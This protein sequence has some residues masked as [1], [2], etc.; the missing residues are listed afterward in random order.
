MTALAHHSNT[1]SQWLVWSLLVTNGFLIALMLALSKTATTQG[2]PATAYAFWQTLI[3]GALLLVR[4][5]SFRTMI[6]RPLVIYFAISGLA[7]IAIPNVLAFY[8]VTKLGT[9]F[10][11]ILYALPPVFTFLIALS[12]GM[13]KR[14]WVKLFGLIV[15]VTACGWIIIQRHSDQAQSSL[16]WYILGLLIPVALS[17]GN[18]YRS[19]AWPKKCAPITLASGTLLACAIM[20]GL[21]SMS[22]NTPLISYDFAPELIEVV[23]LQGVLTAITYLCAFEI[24]KRASPV[25]Y[26]QLG[27]VAAVFGLIIGV[28]WFKEEY[29]ITIWL[30]VL[31]V[32]AGLK[33]SNRMPSQ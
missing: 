5:G 20:L 31:L 33:I 12:M 6:Q 21:F 11:S 19:L 30:G 29:P 10:T 9:G 18:I 16:H 1:A 2:M 15:A 24:Q 28:L 13:E 7:G 8:L 22:T 4:A 26:S 23:L 25:F 14:N 3:A 17:V 32:I 27:A